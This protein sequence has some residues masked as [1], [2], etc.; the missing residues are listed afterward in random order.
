MAERAYVEPVAL[1]GVLR[2]LNPGEEIL[3]ANKVL[4]PLDSPIQKF[5]LV[6]TDRDLTLADPTYCNGLM[7]YIINASNGTGIL[8]VYRSDGVTPLINIQP[9]RVTQCFC[10]NGVWYAYSGAI[11]VGGDVGDT[12]NDGVIDEDDGPWAE[13]PFNTP[14]NYYTETEIDYMFAHLVYTDGTEDLDI[15]TG[16][17]A[18]YT[19]TEIDS[20]FDNLAYSIGT[21]GATA[22]VGDFE[23]YTQTQIDAM[24]ASLCY[25]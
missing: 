19:K 17:L 11:F 20:M 13:T 25:T 4:T 16:P 18:Y 7:M 3:A 22:G 12:N 24:F 14:N 5:D 21:T 6:N 15:A 10:I 1:V 9:N 23:Y 8:S 2:Y